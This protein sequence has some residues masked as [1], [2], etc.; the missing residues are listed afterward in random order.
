MRFLGLTP[1]A[2]AARS[3]GVRLR[4][5]QTTAGGSTAYGAIQFGIASLVVFGTWA[6]SGSRLYAA[7]G[8]MGAFLAWAATFMLLA[9]VLL[10]PLVVGNGNRSRF[11][12]CFA[13]A[14]AGYA[15]VWIASWFA[16]PNRSGEITGAMGGTALFALILCHAFGTPRLWTDTALYL[17]I[18]NAAGYFLGDFAHSHLRGEVGKLAW[19]LLYGLGFGAGIGASL[20]AVQAEIRSRLQVGDVR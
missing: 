3:A 14:F 11:L 9:G 18:G 7:I 17:F 6:V 12:A 4:R 16:M 5:I 15:L 1:E 8:E 10:A 20:F 19:G 13:L 2:V